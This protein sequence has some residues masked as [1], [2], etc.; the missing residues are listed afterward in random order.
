[1][2]HMLADSLGELHEMAARIGLRREWFQALSV[3]HYDL[4]QSKRKLAVQLGAQIVDRH[5]L[6]EVMRRL[7]KGPTLSP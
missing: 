5:G 1:M 7:K 6:V 3:P 2:S 4:C